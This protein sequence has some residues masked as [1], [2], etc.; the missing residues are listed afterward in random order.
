MSCRMQGSSHG[1]RYPP[2]SSPSRPSRSLLARRCTGSTSRSSVGGERRWLFRTKRLYGMRSLP[3]PALNVHLILD[4]PPDHH[5]VPQAPFP[6]SRPSPCSR[7]HSLLHRLP[8]DPSS[9]SPSPN[10]H[11]HKHAPSF[12][13][14]R[15]PHRQTHRHR[16]LRSRSWR[17][18]SWLAA[19]GQDVGALAAYCLPPF[20]SLFP[21]PFSRRVAYWLWG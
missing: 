9:S 19:C 20:A 17:Y 1:P 2:S 10:Q 6:R 14:L 7:P 15:Q 16:H 5:S 12:L 13:S 21:F 3:L 4:T 18:W 11:N 8:Q